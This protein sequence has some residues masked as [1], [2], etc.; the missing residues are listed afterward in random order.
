MYYE[1]VVLALTGVYLAQLFIRR[2]I[3]D[4]MGLKW[5]KFL[6]EKVNEEEIKGAVEYMKGFFE[7]NNENNA[8]KK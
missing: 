2:P 4:F 5:F 3:P 8:K 7:K 6:D 1:P